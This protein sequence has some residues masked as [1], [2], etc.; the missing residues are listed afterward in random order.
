LLPLSAAHIPSPYHMTKDVPILTMAMK[1]Q[2]AF[3]H[4]SGEGQKAAS[5]K[6]IVLKK[7]V[8]FSRF[9]LPMILFFTCVVMHIIQL[10]VQTW[11]TLY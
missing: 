10:S 5:Q 11:K 9:A 8:F 6:L 4:Q 3:R 7:T 2:N 1:Y